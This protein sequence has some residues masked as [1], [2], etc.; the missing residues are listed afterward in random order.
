MTRDKQVEHRSALTRE[1][2]ADMLRALARGVRKGEFR[3]PGPKRNVVFHP[4]GD[5]Q[6]AMTLHSAPH[7]GS[8]DIE[9]RWTYVPAEE[10]LTR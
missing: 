5:I 3:V 2:A 9:L 10:D 7:T 1:E 4:R 6:L 8:L